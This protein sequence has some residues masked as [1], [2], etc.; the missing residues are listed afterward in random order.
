MCALACLVAEG[1]V[2]EQG[3]DQARARVAAY[4][5]RRQASDAHCRNHATMR[6]CA[7]ASLRIHAIMRSCAFASLRIHAFTHSRNHAIV[8]VR[9]A[10]HGRR[11]VAA[12]KRVSRFAAIMPLDRLR[13]WAAPLRSHRQQRRGRRLGRLRKIGATSAPVPLSNWFSKE[14]AMRLLTGI[15][16]PLALSAQCAAGTAPP[17][18]NHPILG[19]WRLT[20]ADS[21]CSE[22]YRFRGDGTSLVTSAGEVSE[23]EFDIPAKPSEKGFYRLEDRV[24]KGN[25]KKD[26]SGEI[27][28]VGSKATN[29]IRFHPSGA[30]FLMCATESM[31]LCIGPFERMVGPAI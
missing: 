17:A 5:R 27:M 25:G 1:M 31:D 12:G 9:I 4:E 16:L 29:F 8:R 30:L 22:I 10:A 13:A 14:P 19:I 6:A 11:P 18:T 24:V 21:R 2:G 7:F 15:L 26:C 23:S 28:K 20:L 3:G